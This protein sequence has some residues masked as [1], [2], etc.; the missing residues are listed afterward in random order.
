[1]QS[2]YITA[3]KV[4]QY[5]CVIPWHI[6]FNCSSS[7]KKDLLHLFIY[8]L[9]NE[10]FFFQTFTLAVAQRLHKLIHLHLLASIVRT[11]LSTGFI[12]GIKLGSSLCTIFHPRE[13][14]R[15]F[16]AWDNSWVYKWRLSVLQVH[17]CAEK[18][19]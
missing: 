3:G 14:D 13:T 7:I 17:D 5:R 8:I 2:L 18:H 15:A 1:M 10:Q 9:T 16:H 4:H 11:Q 12:I 19:L 6:Y